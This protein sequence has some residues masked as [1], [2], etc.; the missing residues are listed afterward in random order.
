MADNPEQHTPQPEPDNAGGEVVSEDDLDALLSE[1]SALASEI[2]GEVGD[3][4]MNAVQPADEDSAVCDAAASESFESWAGDNPD[5]VDS[6][7]AALDS[8]L[9]DSRN[10]VGAPTPS[11]VVGPPSDDSPGE[12]DQADQVIADAVD[13]EDGFPGDVHVSPSPPEAHVPDFMQELTQPDEESSLR[14]SDT[15]HDQNS[16][17]SAAPPTKP[18][19]QILDRSAM[20]RAAH[21]EVKPETSEST[22]P[23]EQARVEAPPGPPSPMRSLLPRVRRRLSPVAFRVSE[24]GVDLLEV[25]N[26]PL[27]RFGGRAQAAVGWLAIATIGTSLLVF[28]VS[29]F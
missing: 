2:S 18:P 26:R 16:S 19:P 23:T 25:L 12:V 28:L 27:G 22:K 5:D 14:H 10:E 8:L 7:L 13:V 4:S 6:R 3:V 29:L 15:A 11:D 21:D 17:I 20:R 1:A 9:E 24:K